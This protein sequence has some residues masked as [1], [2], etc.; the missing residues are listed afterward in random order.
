MPEEGGAET[1]PFTNWRELIKGTPLQK[2]MVRVKEILV[3][4]E[5]QG[6]TRPGRALAETIVQI[7]PVAGSLDEMLAE[8]R[9][10]GKEWGK[11][12]RD[13]PQVV[14]E[15][16]AER[17]GVSQDYLFASEE[18]KYEM[19]ALMMDHIID[20]DVLLTAAAETALEELDKPS[21]PS[22]TV[23]RDLSIRES[24]RRFKP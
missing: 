3:G 14:A 8:A 24:R 11:F 4:W 20:N 9:R 23:G 18:D 1:S 16:V 2:D 19:L 7:N 17:G 6:E 12:T 15:G 13:W 10:V 22:R 21:L 5:N